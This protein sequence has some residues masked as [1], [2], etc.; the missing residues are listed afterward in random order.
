MGRIRKGLVVGL[1][2]VALVLGTTPAAQATEVGSVT[3]EGVATVTP[4]LG[5][6]NPATKNWS[7]TSQVCVATHVGTKKAPAAA[8]GCTIT[9][10]GTLTGPA[11]NV[12]GASCAS[13]SGTGSGILTIGSVNKYSFTVNWVASGAA[14]ILITGSITKTAGPGTG[15]TGTFTASVTVAPEPVGVVGGQSCAN[16]SQRDFLV[17]GEA[18]YSI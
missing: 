12:V 2:V 17:I 14:E 8:Q 4:G 7:F 15:Q 6:P 13:T 3:F 18:A 16:K 11:G 10:N 9:A 5:L 1:G